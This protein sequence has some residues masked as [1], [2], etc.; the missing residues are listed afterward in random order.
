MDIRLLT[1]ADI[2]AYVVLRRE[3][4]EDS[5]WA[6]SSSPGDDLGLKPDILRERLAEPGH[7]IVGAFEDAR[8][9][10]S[11]GV[12]RERQAKVAHRVRIWGVYVAPAARGR[13]IGAAV[14]HRT[15]E[16][17]RSWPGVN[18]AGLSASSRSAEA[19]RLYKKLGFVEWGVE[20]AAMMV[21]GQGYDEIHMVATLNGG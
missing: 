8:L 21:N 3:M 7:A 19:V 16:I 15:L 4:L 13:G 12:Y 5:P 9:V 11:A 1:V 2:P 18:S 10:A 17:A 20:P 14:M 6:F